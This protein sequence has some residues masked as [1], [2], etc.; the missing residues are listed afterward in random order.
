MFFFLPSTEC[1][2]M[3]VFEFVAGV[4]F[5]HK[6]AVRMTTSETNLVRQSRTAAAAAAGQKQSPRAKNLYSH[7]SFT[8]TWAI[9][10]EW[11]E[12][13]ELCSEPPVSPA[14]HLIVPENRWQ[15]PHQI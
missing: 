1:A 2:Q 10:L 8:I 9:N 7:A 6:G 15:P 13:P 14:V 12:S 4:K 11:P 5:T 3:W